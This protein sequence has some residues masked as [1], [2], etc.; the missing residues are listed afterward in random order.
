MSKITDIKFFTENPGQDIFT[1]DEELDSSAAHTS[2][3]S[4]SSSQAAVSNSASLFSSK[5]RKLTRGKQK[6]PISFMQDRVRRCSTFSKRKT[7]LMKKAFELAEL[8]GAEVLL[9]VASETNHVYT[10]TTNRLKAI[11]DSDQ[12]RELIQSCLGSRKPPPSPPPPPTPTQ[13][14]VIESTESAAPSD[15]SEGVTQTDTLPQTVS[16]QMPNGTRLHLPVTFSELVSESG[17]VLPLLSNCNGNQPSAEKVTSP[18]C[19]TFPNGGTQLLSASGIK[20]PPD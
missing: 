19:L 14:S 11:I 1:D 7:G 13:P 6:I 18:L 4:S 16:I 2:P 5:R 10:F 8:T 17:L 3:S 9:L 12:G 20:P 15:G